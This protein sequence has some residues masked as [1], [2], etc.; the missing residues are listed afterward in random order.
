MFN[1]TNATAKLKNCLKKF[2][3]AGISTG[4]WLSKQPGQVFD[5]S[6]APY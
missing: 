6:I 4:S 5:I 2:S 1:L 3:T